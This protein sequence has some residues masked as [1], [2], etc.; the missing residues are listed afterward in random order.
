M[1]QHSLQVNVAPE[2]QAGKERRKAMMLPACCSPEL[3]LYRDAEKRAGD[4]REAA[5]GPAPW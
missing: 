1:V 4:G 2:V 5:G 3:T